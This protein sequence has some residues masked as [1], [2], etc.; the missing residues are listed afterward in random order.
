MTKHGVMGYFLKRPPV[1]SS[2]K[3]QLG[4]PEWMA[5]KTP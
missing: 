2:D 4:V 1:V 3:Y 5:S